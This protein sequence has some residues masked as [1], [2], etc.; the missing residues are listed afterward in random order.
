MA[1]GKRITQNQVIGEQGA[2]IVKTRV[3]AMGFLYT[4]Y[5]PVEAGIDLGFRSIHYYL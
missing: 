1:R 5:G 2:A 4:P 3:H